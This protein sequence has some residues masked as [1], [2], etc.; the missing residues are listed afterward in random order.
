VYAG[1]PSVDPLTQALQR[2][3]VERRIPIDYPREL[4]A[5]FAM[6][7]ENRRYRTL[8]E[9]LR[10]CHRVAGTVGLMM[11]HVLGVS[12]ERALASAARLGIGMQLTNI[13]RDVY[14]DWQRGRLYI[15]REILARAGAA[16]LFDHTRAPLRSELRRALATAL[17]MLLREARSW[18]AAAEPGFRALPWR[19]SLAIRTARHLYAAIGERIRQLGFDVFAGRA[20]VP[21]PVKLW[22]CAIGAM[23]A[24]LELPGRALFPH[25][26]IAIRRVTRF[27]DDVTA[28]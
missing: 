21:L 16:E 12:D 11:A 3:V 28:V 20:V 26:A 13:C 19:A 5:G 22:W 23:R 14:E 24:L 7:V 4:L 18:Y 25:R 17:E 6:D 1:R 9:L 15:P 8:D 2:V 10:Y 27:P